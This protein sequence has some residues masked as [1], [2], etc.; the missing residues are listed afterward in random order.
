MGEL[1]IVKVQISDGRILDGRLWI[2]DDHAWR[3][4][5]EIESE[6]WEC[7]GKD[8]FSAIRELRNILDQRGWRLLCAAARFDVYPSGMSREMGGARKAYSTSL[9]QPARLSNLIDILDFAP[10]VL[11][12]T[13]HEQDAFHE[14]WIRSLKK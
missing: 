11:V 7:A 5:L 1:N 13:V 9:G 8:L 12:G 2:Y 10:A 6:I 3:V 4:T 14:K